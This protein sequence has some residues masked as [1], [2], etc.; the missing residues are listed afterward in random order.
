[1]P[2]MTMIHAKL[3]IYIDGDFYAFLEY[4]IQEVQL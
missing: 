4:A 1:M 3:K 2:S